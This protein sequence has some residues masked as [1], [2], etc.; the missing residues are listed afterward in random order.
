MCGI[1]GGFSFT[2][3]GG[4]V[5]RQVVARLNEWQRR[6]GPDGVG[7]WASPDERVV[8]GHRRLA[9]IETGAAG[10][11]PM[12]DPS[13]RWVI[14]F[15]GEIYNYRELRSELE[16]AGRTFATNSDTEVLINVVAEWG[17]PGL[18]KLRGMFAFALWDL[19]ERELWLVRDPYGIK[20][21]YIA[22]TEDTIWFASQA[23]ALATCAP[24][25]TARSAPGLAGFYLWGYVPEPFTWWE[26]IRLLPA[27][28]LQRFRVGELPD[29]PKPFMVVEDLYKNFEPRELSVDELQEILLETMRY[30]LVADVPVG[31]LLSAGVDSNAIAALA[32]RLGQRLTAVTMRF[33]EFVGTSQDETKLAAD[34]A[35]QLGIRHVIST[36]TRDEFEVAC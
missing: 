4:P 6:R 11:Q 22:E 10:A 17:E 2:A 13:G 29:A 32:A 9:I 28:H 27:G 36:I 20:P 34:M 15:N 31:V 19:F 26:T 18:T 14:S 33:R 8:L 21:L 3:D 23:R 25:N 5:D 7:L 16:R 24:I 35:Q 1:A 12:T 30:H